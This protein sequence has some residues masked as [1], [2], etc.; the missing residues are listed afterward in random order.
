MAEGDEYY[1]PQRAQDA[2]DGLFEAYQDQG[3]SD[4]EIKGVLQIQTPD[5]AWFAQRG[6]TRNYHGG[7]NVVFEEDS[8]LN[9]I[10]SHSK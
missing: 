7:G 1:G 8:I 9:W 6:V 5:A 3:W 2:Y 4:E 10:L